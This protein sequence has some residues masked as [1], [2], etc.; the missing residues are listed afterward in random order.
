MSKIITRLRARRALALPFA[1][2][3]L[4][5]IGCT[6]EVTTRP[7]TVVTAQDEVVVETAPPNIYAYP[8]TV[9]RGETVYYVG[10]RWYQRR[11]PR[12]VYYRHEPA[13]LVRHRHHVEAAPPAR[14]YQPVPGEAI[15]VR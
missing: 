4:A 12:W 9:Y 13:D 7:A 1:L 15:R 6:A 10:G 3:A 11:G 2:T 8:Q 5:A 14:R